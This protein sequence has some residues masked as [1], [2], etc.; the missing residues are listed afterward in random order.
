MNEFNGFFAQA[1]WWL[2]LFGGLHCLALAIY[3]RYFYQAETHQNLLASF[4][5]LIA[6]YFLTGLI[7]RDNA[8]IPIHLLFNLIS[9]IY[10]LLMPL[11]YLYCKNSLNQTNQPIAFSKH[12]W[13]ALLTLLFAII[14]IVIKLTGYQTGKWPSVVLIFSELNISHWSALLP[15]L[16]S[17]QTCYYFIALWMLF[18]RHKQKQTNMTSSQETLGTIRFRWLI[19]LTLAML[20]NWLI[21][22]F[23]VILPF[24]FGDNLSLL[25][26][27]LPRLTLLLSI[28]ML[29]VYGLKQITRSAYLKGRMTKQPSQP[30]VIHNVLTPEEYEFLHQVQ[31]DDGD[32]K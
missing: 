32:Q 20:L 22:V 15:A 17:I 26:N 23:V 2:S 29:A 5:S 13:P 1:Y 18:H 25:S 30:H 8:P 7:N 14:D 9:P 12:Y 3:I 4:L 11:L 10:F 6:L 27:A 28:Y 31:Q 21:R 16:L 24:Y 19:G